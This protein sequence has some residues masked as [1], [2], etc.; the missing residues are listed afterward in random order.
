MTPNHTR[1]SAPF[2]MAFTRLCE[3]T[4][5]SGWEKLYCP[6]W[7]TRE[8]RNNNKAVKKK[9]RITS[10]LPQ[11][12]ICNFNTKTPFLPEE[13]ETKLKKIAEI[14]DFSIV[15]LKFECL[16]MIAIKFSTNL[17]PS[18]PM[19]LSPG[20]PECKWVIGF[21]SFIFIC[22]MLLK[23]SLT[24]AINVIFVFLLF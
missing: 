23:Y 1:P 6:V 17:I 3:G 13:W 10:G 16:N 19:R 11:Q 9:K 15:Q 7:S 12:S 20:P 2:K 5:S 22:P 4:L 14:V 8:I 21:R 18:H 24:N